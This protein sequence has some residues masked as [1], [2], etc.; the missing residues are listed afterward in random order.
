SR[1]R[2]QNLWQSSCFTLN[3]LIKSDLIDSS[4]SNEYDWL[5]DTPEVESSAPQSQGSNSPRADPQLVELFKS[6]NDQSTT[7]TDPEIITYIR[8]YMDPNEKFYIQN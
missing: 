1:S 7:V 6:V 2:I 4:F 5:F 8:E 3:D